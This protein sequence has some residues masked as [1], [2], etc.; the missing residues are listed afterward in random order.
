LD[1]ADLVVIGTINAFT[2]AGQAELVR[3]LLRREIPLIIIAMRLPYDLVVFPDAPTYL[4][5]YSILE[6]SMQA[7]ARALFGQAEMTGQLPVTI[8]AANPSN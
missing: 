7:V 6:P 8:P 5:T 1:G 4:C 2:Q 3:R